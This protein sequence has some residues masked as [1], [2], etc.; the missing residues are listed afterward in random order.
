MPRAPLV[1]VTR[2]PTR[3]AWLAARDVDNRLSASDVVRILHPTAWGGPWDV[4][5]RKVYGIAH[6]PSYSVQADLERGRDYEPLVLRRYLAETG[7]AAESFGNAL[8][9]HPN[10][11]LVGTPDALVGDGGVELKTDRIR[12]GWGPTGTTIEQWS[13]GAELLVKPRYAIQVYVYLEATGRPWWDLAVL[14]PQ[15]FDFPELRIFRFLRDAETQAAIVRV[16]GAWRDRHL[17]AE[18]PPPIDGS[19]ACSRVLA[20]DGR[21]GKASKRDATEA[22]RVLVR[23]LAIAKIAEEGAKAA[24][25]LAANHLAVT[26]ADGKGLAL[27]PKTTL[28]WVRSE[29]RPTVDVLALLAARPDLAD[30]VEQ[31]RRPGEPYAFPRLYPN[32]AAVLKALED[33]HG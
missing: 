15:A 7:Q 19:G 16:V 6:E 22:E 14:I 31:Y 3:D 27:A 8:V 25:R 23:Q 29:G 28:T 32:P 9:H 21:H 26:I 33:G 12:D 5:A 13:E 10:G 11:W 17:V 4:Y 20:E 24:G 30:V 18:E 1:K 2:F